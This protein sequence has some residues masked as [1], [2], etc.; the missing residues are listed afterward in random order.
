MKLCHR[1]RVS[2]FYSSPSQSSVSTPANH[3][4]PITLYPA[5]LANNLSFNLSREV[6]LSVDSLQTPVTHSCSTTDMYHG[7]RFLEP[8]SSLIDNCSFTNSIFHMPTPLTTPTDEARPP[9]GASEDL[10]LPLSVDWAAVLRN[11]EAKQQRLLLQHLSSQSAASSTASSKLSFST[12]SRSS[13]NEQS[14]DDMASPLLGSFASQPSQVDRLGRA[15]G[16]VSV[17]SDSD[18]T[19]CSAASSMES[20]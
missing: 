7:K 10:R 17:G 13:F 12:P 5:P 2:D 16:S 20:L 6:T 11:F 1:Q 4:R 9:L 3:F 8:V 19:I 15:A 18:A 14:S